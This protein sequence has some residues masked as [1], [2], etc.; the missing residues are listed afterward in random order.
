LNV[1]INK[2][3]FLLLFLDGSGCMKTFYVEQQ[4]LESVYNFLKLDK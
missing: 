4:R 3:R 1:T 2:I